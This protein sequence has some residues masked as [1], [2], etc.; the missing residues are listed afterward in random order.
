MLNI[1]KAE[2]PVD[3]EILSCSLWLALRLSLALSGSPWLPL[4][5][6]G[7]L[8]P[9]IAALKICL[10]S[11]IAI[12]VVISQK[13]IKVV[14]PSI[15]MLN[16]QSSSYHHGPNQFCFHSPFLLKPQN[17]HTLTLGQSSNKSADKWSPPS[18]RPE[19]KT[20]FLSF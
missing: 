11:P 7:S 16:L 4:A 17:K 18:S 19:K 13:L 12:F 15:L 1:F 5:L 20:G 14:W 2:S 8:W 3:S 9:S 6:S 10:Q